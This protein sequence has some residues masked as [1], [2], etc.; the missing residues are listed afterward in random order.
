MSLRKLIISL[1]MALLVGAC[2]YA[3]SDIELD[4]YD[5]RARFPIG[6]ESDVI[7]TAFGGSSSGAMTEKERQALSQVVADYKYRGQAPLIVFVG[8]S[9]LNQDN[10]AEDIRSSAVASGLAKSEVLVSIDPSLRPEEVQVS[11]MSY[12]AVLPE[13]GYWQQE[14]YMN[15]ENSNSSNFGCAT[16]HNLGLMLADPSDLIDPTPFDLRDG[17]RTAT[18]VDLYRAGEVTGAEHN[19]STSSIVDIGN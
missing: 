2:T 17:V 3:D 18:V 19:E 13:C 14:S 16:Q 9:G 1:A 8:Q 15:L 4:D 5:Y 7:V 12:T 10:L 6:V 11:F